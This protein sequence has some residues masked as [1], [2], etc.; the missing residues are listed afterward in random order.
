MKS[1]NRA[2]IIKIFTAVL[3]VCLVTVTA[4]SVGEPPEQIPCGES[5]TPTEHESPDKTTA[6]AEQSLLAG[7]ALTVDVV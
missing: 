3:M 4:C 2:N 6:P 1:I 7:N 5:G